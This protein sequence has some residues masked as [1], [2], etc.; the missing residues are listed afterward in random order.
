MTT[1]YATNGIPMD[2]NVAEQILDSGLSHLTVSVN[3]PNSKDYTWFH[4]VN[5]FQRVIDNLNAFRELRDRRGAKGPEIVAKIMTLSRWEDQIEAGLEQLKNGADQTVRSHVC[6][7]DKGELENI[8]SFRR[9]DL[10][11][12]Q[13]CSS[14]SQVMIVYP[15]GLFR[16]CC[17]PEFTNE[18]N[19]VLGD[20]HKDH[21]LNVWRSE[22]YR[23]LRVANSR[24]EAII[25]SCRSCN[26]DLPDLVTDVLIKARQREELSTH[27]TNQKSVG[28]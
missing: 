3:A 19:P 23:K 8:E 24:G 10:P 25:D 13:T 4:G 9:Q 20:A 6:F 21:F 18:A 14:L 17:A 15:D 27:P 1:E 11:F 2:E 5:A 26:V 7:V 28:V 12:V 22:A 16:V